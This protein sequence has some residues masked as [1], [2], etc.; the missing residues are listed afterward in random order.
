MSDGKFIPVKRRSPE[1]RE[2]YM[3][4]YSSAIASA[5]TIVATACSVGNAIALLSV[6]EQ[7]TQPTKEGLDD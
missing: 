3:Q 6:H 4:G 2:A 5:K 7:M 1:C